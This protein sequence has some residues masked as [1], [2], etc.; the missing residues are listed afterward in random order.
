[1]TQSSP[2]R[3]PVNDTV[4]DL[5]TVAACA[6]LVLLVLPLVAPAMVLTLG[7]PYAATRA[8]YWIVP[9]W[10]R[11]V[12][13]GGIAAVVLLLSIE[14][15]LAA[16]WI[17]DEHALFARSLVTVVPALWGAAWPWLIVNACS[18]LL[19]V[20]AAM[21]LRRRRLAQQVTRRQVADVLLQE[22]IESARARAAAWTASRRMG[23]RVN[24]QTGQIVS[25]E[26]AIVAPHPVRSGQ[27]FGFVAVPTISTWRDRFADLRR[28][29]DW[30]D[31]VAQ[32][33]VLP[34]KSSAAR[35]LVLAESGTGKTVLLN[36]MIGC[37]LASGWPVF[38]ID[39]KGDPAD[40]D[41]LVRAARAA[42]RS[43]AVGS[44]WNLFAGTAEQVTEKLMRLLPPADGANQHYLD[45]ARGVLGMVQ[46]NSP[47]RS[48]AELR[49]RLEHPAPHLRDE[50]DLHAV[51]AVVDSRAGLTAAGRVLQALM[52]ALRPLEEWID[53]AGWSYSH[54]NADVTVMS[55]SPVDVTQA[56]LG[57]LLMVDLRH[58]L[59]TRLRAG[60]KSPVLVV[61][62]EF[63][64]LVT[65]DSDPGDAA[66]ALLETAR[67]SGAGLILAAQSTAGLSND[68][69]RRARALASGAALIIGRSKDPDT[70]VRYA[71]TVLRLENAA[72]ALGESLLSGRAQHTYVIPPQAVREAWDGS[73]WLV[74][75]GGIA[76]F[77]TMP[78]ARPA[79]AAAQ[80]AA[81]VLLPE[82]PTATEPELSDERDERKPITVMRRTGPKP[83][84]IPPRHRQLAQPSSALTTV[85]DEADPITGLE[86]LL[87]E[88]E[89]GRWSAVAYPAT[90]SEVLDD[91]PHP[92]EVD[93]AVPP[94]TVGVPRGS[95][96]EEWDP[97]HFDGWG[98][99][100]HQ[101]PV[102]WTD[103]L[104]RLAA[105]ARA[106]HR[107]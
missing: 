86:I 31:P 54:P 40:A 74:Q 84:F 13:G 49:D 22:R 37:A 41:E 63:P 95:W 51:Q 106:R 61:V 82:Q 59:A 83:T 34:A 97:D 14:G 18:G 68:E 46:A 33:V 98:H 99:P 107:I 50:A 90:D 92:D 25:T 57:H 64:Q 75:A 43:A 27:A 19:L 85:R 102:M 62:D 45:E 80:P 94:E 81:A 6:V 30:V 8:R 48:V 91:V 4:A 77:R 71:G 100:A 87:T 11:L 103:A 3:D 36:G 93:F 76:A 9:H 66:A 67:S 23:V 10:W 79:I 21:A 1:V 42:G 55:L 69:G 65:L 70:A 60:D 5:V 28:V 72:S 16:V 104:D 12:V 29:R 56:R 58:F 38:V 47:I 88:H 32:A 52:P 39:A 96:V 24:S 101:L 2:R 73:F 78:P 20:P 105:T 89:P 26:R 15:L 44:R 7:S 17:R 35:A 53:A